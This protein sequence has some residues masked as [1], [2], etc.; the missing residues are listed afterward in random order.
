M[1]PLVNN[2]LIQ[3]PQLP[4]TYYQFLKGHHVRKVGKQCPPTSQ[5]QSLC[6]FVSQHPNEWEEGWWS[7]GSGISIGQCIAVANW[8]PNQN[9]AY[10]KSSQFMDYLEVLMDSESLWGLSPL[11]LECSHRRETRNTFWYILFLS[12]D[13]LLMM[14]LSP[15]T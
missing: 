7:F 12:N 10:I 13:Y 6:L 4:Y 8:N 3:L 1:I 11:F 9:I 2:S 5:P 15:S 14:V